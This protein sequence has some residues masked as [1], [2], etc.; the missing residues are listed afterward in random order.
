MNLDRKPLEPLEVIDVD[1]CSIVIEQP[2]P[3][4][5]PEQIG[6]GAVAQISASC[7]LPNREQLDK[8]IARLVQFANELDAAKAKGKAA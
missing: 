4:A 2:D 8:L 5:F 3:K 7:W 6:C 1:S